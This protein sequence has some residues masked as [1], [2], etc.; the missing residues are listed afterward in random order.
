MTMTPGKTMEVQF[1]FERRLKDHGVTIYFVGTPDIA[2]D[3]IPTRWEIIR[4]A[5]V[6][7]G[8]AD[9]EF[10]GKGGTKETYREAFERASELPLEPKQEAAA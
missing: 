2:A 10:G 3:C 7:F 6:N 4:T 5:I 9:R 1:F 8:L